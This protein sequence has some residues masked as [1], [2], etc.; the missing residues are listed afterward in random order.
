MS[1]LDRQSDRCFL[2]NYS[3]SKLN[4][5]YDAFITSIFNS[6]A[7]QSCIPSTG[8]LYV[9][10]SSKITLVGAKVGPKFYSTY[11]T[12]STKVTTMQNFHSH[13]GILSSSGILLSSCTTA[14]NSTQTSIAI[15]LYRCCFF[16]LKTRAKLAI[17]PTNGLPSNRW[18]ANICIF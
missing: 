15:V 11:S 16:K 7:V 18:L 9:A 4:A 5:C 12:Y 14:R 6:S 8:G 3:R 2:L 1:K 13:L 10:S 17:H